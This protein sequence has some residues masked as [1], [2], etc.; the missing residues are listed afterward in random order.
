[1]TERDEKVDVLK[2]EDQDI[3]Q[4][5]EVLRDF[6]SRLW[7]FCGS[8]LTLVIGYCVLGETRWQPNMLDSDIKKP[9]NA[10]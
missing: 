5:C 9:E 4:D 6:K 2:G 8:R 3:L 7:V 1:M 10:L